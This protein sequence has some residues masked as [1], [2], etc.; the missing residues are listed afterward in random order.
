MYVFV[1]VFIL[2][3][4]LR[5]YFCRAPRRPDITDGTWEADRWLAFTASHVSTHTIF[6]LVINAMPHQ[7]YRAF[8]YQWFR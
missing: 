6:I 8:F 1:S 3:L 5:I 7:V 4:F 2:T